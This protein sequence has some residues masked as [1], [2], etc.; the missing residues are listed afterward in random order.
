MDRIFAALSSAR[1]Q[2]VVWYV[3]VEGLGVQRGA[4]GRKVAVVSSRGSG[5]MWEKGRWE[6]IKLY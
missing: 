3:R 6:V 5:G 2:R 4:K 1:R